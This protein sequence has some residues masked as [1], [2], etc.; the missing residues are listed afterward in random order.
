MAVSLNHHIVRVADQRASAEYYAELLG[1][2]PP[3]PFG[4]FLVLELAHG[5]SLDFYDLDGAG[6]AQHYAFLVTEDEFDEILA[7]IRRLGLT[8]YADPGGEQANEW[9][10]H[11]GGRG[12]YWS[13]LDGHWLEILT[14]PYGSGG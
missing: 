3:R 7:R 8:F 5:L 4:P 10:T 2:E 6:T 1:L 11:D 14:R 13:D 12:L 9:N